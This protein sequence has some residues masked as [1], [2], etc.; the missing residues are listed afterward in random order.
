M[1]RFLLACLLFGVA[2][3][4]IGASPIADLLA[5]VEVLEATVVTQVKSPQGMLTEMF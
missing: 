1:R 3:L 2:A 4:T 5:R